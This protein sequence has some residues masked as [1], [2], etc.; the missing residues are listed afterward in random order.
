MFRDF[1]PN[2][3]WGYWTCQGTLYYQKRN[4]VYPSFMKIL[5]KDQAKTYTLITI[6]LKTKGKH[7][8]RKILDM[9]LELV[10]SLYPVSNLNLNRHSSAVR[11]KKT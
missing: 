9:H 10:F 2:R 5:L 3:K 1:N 6:K 11:Q 8:W 4:T 7:I